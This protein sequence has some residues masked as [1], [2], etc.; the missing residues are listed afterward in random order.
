[1]FKLRNYQNKGVEAC[2]EVL[3]SKV[4]TKQVVVAPTGAG[5]SIYIAYAA[6]AVDYPLIILQPS[7]ELLKQ[8]YS[9]FTQI[10]GKASIYSVSTKEFQR[11]G[12]AYTI[13]D[14][15]EIPCQEIGHITYATI[16]SI[17]KD[18]EKFKNLKVRGIIIDEC[19]LNTQKG[20]QIKA[21]IKA[22]KIKNV[23]GLTATPVYLSNS[24]EGASLKI[25]TRV[26]N[27]L[28]SDIRHVT[29]IQELVK[30]K[31]WSP[32]V[33]R[34]FDEDGAVLKPN[35]NGS[36][37]TEQ[38]Q[39]EFYE[40]N[41]IDKKVKVIVE[42]LRIQGK[43]K[44]ILI[45]VPTIASAEALSL[46]IKNSKV[47]HSKMSMSDR[48]KVIEDFRNLKIDVVINVNILSVGFDHQQLDTII[49]TRP[50]MSI[51]I[52][53]QQCIDK[54]TEILTK[55]GFLKY[56]ELTKEDITYGYDINTG[57]IKDNKIKSI[58][59]R[60]QYDFEN[61]INYKNNRIDF[62][63]SSE[64]D[65]IFKSRKT[66]N[67][68]KSKSIEMLKHKSSMHV[69]VSGFEKS[70]GIPLKNSELTLLGWLLSDG[71][72]HKK[73]KVLTISQSSSS[74]YIKE[75]EKCIKECGFEI[76]FNIIKRKN[77]KYSD[78]INY[79]IPYKSTKSK[80]GW[81]YLEKWFNKNISEDLNDI[82]RE[83]LKIVMTSIIKGDGGNKNIKDWNVKTHMIY[84]GNNEIY[85][86]NLQSLLVRRGFYC[87]L[88]YYTEV[89]NNKDFG[90]IG[91]IS[92]LIK[93]SYSDIQKC[94]VTGNNE[95]DGVILN[96]KSYKRSRLQVEKNKNN[97][98]WCVDTEMGTIITR[99]KGK[100]M[101]MGNCGRGVRIHPT[102][103]SCAILDFSGNFQRFGKVEELNFEHIEGYGW[104][105]FKGDIL[106]SDYPMMGINRPTKKSLAL[107]RGKSGFIKFD[108]GKYKGKTIDEVG[109]E[110][111]GYLVWMYD[112]FTF[113]G[114][115]GRVLKEDIKNY[116]KL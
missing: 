42:K 90:K 28:F 60:L 104:G 83:Q 113:R 82:T 58:I 15:K 40:L 74:P 29:Q 66:K 18:L 38:S 72:I 63:V 101:I 17:M 14:G 24:M 19:H 59:N 51:G 71:N 108:F 22:V 33:Y 3:L 12:V 4:T 81:D 27:K 75:I 80:K 11:K 13:I 56:N 96:K 7:K 8:N 87:K 30:N 62:R 16:G 84:M 88:T 47:V 107:F 9:K 97:E 26:R 2:K 105:M 55:R 45:F 50:T 65:M 102:K 49:T 48:Q 39:K 10:G 79:R 43:R 91:R 95:K 106:L 5:K 31:Y 36:D 64:H 111:K 73:N 34:V 67:Y 32:L 112:K 89:N 37:F 6:N 103:A 52:Y 41:N 94:T 70:N 68:K 86:N 110:D 85:S 69:P 93:L 21:F 44:S 78:G 109:R 23:L 92:K 53:Y 35:S 76:K 77:K 61:I 57:E 116:L 98:L 25:I 100:V 54:E 114:E 20:S 46:K 1:M 99:R 115:K